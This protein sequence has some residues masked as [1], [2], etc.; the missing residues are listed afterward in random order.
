MSLIKILFPLFSSQSPDGWWGEWLIAKEVV[1]ENANAQ[2]HSTIQ[3]FWEKIDILIVA[4][5][6]PIRVSI[7]SR[8]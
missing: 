4:V 7:Y 5:F 3:L 2:F 1:Y 6:V 8:V